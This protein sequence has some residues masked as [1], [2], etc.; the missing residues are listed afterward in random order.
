LVNVMVRQLFGNKKKLTPEIK[1]YFKIPFINSY[2]RK[3]SWVLPKQIIN[4]SDWLN[5]LH[6]QIGQIKDKNI[7]IAWGLKDIGFRKKELLKWKELLPNAK[8]VEYSDAGHF[9]SEEKSAEIV[10]EIESMFTEAM[11]KL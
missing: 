6:D 9:V 5:S 3:G 11:N 4:S 2:D 7:V 8:V 1:N 10:I